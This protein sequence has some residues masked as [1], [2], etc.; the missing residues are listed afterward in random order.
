MRAEL[1]KVMNEAIKEFEKYGN[2]KAVRAAEILKNYCRGFG[3]CKGCAFF[4][5]ESEYK[6]DCMLL[7]LV[8]DHWKLPEEKEEM[9]R[10]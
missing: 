1:R 2:M 6:P 7:A 8:P 10:E 5:C 4:V 9:E 3:S